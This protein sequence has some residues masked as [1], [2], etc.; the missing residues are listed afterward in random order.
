MF[1]LRLLL[2]RPNELP[3]LGP[4]G[5]DYALLYELA[6]DLFLLLADEALA[7]QLVGGLALIVLL[8]QLFFS[9]LV[10]QPLKQQLVLLF[11]LG[12]VKRALIGK[13]VEVVVR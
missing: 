7:L 2:L 10:R 12:E 11:I 1:V 9:L 5:G 13:N 8:L 3:P 6:G 4:A